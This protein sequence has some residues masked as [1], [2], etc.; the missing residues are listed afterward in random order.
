MLA[1]I[2]R[3]LMQVRLLACSVSLTGSSSPI[4]ALA[5][6][7]SI[8]L[9]VLCSAGINPKPASPSQVTLFCSVSS[10]LSRV[11]T[12]GP[13]HSLPTMSQLCCN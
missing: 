5:S 1:P 9:A 4:E 7:L 11:L 3:L 2:L 8:W 13:E 6:D 10:Q 12:A